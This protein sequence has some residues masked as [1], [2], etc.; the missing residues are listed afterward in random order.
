MNGLADAQTMPI[1]FKADSVR[2]F[3]IPSLTADIAFQ[4]ILRRIPTHIF[5]F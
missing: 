3:E 5:F 2:Y 1:C 4:I